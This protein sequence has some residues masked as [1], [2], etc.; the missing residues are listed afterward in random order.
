MG[1]FATHP[2][3]RWK[4]A[5]RVAGSGSSEPFRPGITRIV[6]SKTDRWSWQHIWEQEIKPH[7]THVSKTAEA[8]PSAVPAPTAAPPA[9]PATP[10]IAKYVDALKKFSAKT[11]AT[12]DDID[13][14]AAEVMSDL[15]GKLDQA[16]KDLEA[17]S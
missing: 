16:I 14:R 12:L 2:A 9:V 17:A 11:K 4:D 5:A 8:S 10:P 1:E 3:G 13:G 15:L 6:L 7:L